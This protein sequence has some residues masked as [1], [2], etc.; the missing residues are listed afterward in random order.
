MEDKKE[1]TVYSLKTVIIFILMVFKFIADIL[2]SLDKMKKMQNK[3]CKLCH[4][5]SILMNA[6]LCSFIFSQYQFCIRASLRRKMDFQSVIEE[7]EENVY[8]YFL[9]R[10]TWFAVY[11]ISRVIF[12]VL[13]L[14]LNGIIIIV[15]LKKFRDLKG[16]DVMIVNMAMSQIIFGF[17]NLFFL[18]DDINHELTDHSLC[19]AK[20]FLHSFQ[21]TL[22]IYSCL[23]LMIC[24]S[25]FEKNLKK[26]YAVIC[27]MIVW[28]VSIFISYPY[29]ESYLVP[30]NLKN[31]Q[32]RNVCVTGMESFEHL[33]RYRYNHA[34]LSYILPFLFLIGF[35]LMAFIKKREELKN[36]NLLLYPIIYTFYFTIT[37]FYIELFDIALLLFKI[38]PNLVIFFIFK[39]LYSKNSILNA[40]AY[41]YVDSEF[42]K[43][44]LQF[45][46]LSPKNSKNVRYVKHEDSHEIENLF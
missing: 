31:G 12:C 9:N 38:K 11:S 41:F 25:F 10:P 27:V 29:N 8:E 19:N 20:Y 5:L 17:G 33:K 2:N 1:T 35:L 30:I 23:A 21:L 7:P 36:K 39:F 28:N 4:N 45:L 13:A 15:K 26:N 18:I 3:Y 24:A 22:S 34:T 6:L 14:I 44:C 32:R 43:K 40:I 42:Y 46:R 16:I 37:S